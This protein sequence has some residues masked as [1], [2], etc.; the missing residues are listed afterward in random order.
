MGCGCGGTESSGPSPIESG[1]SYTFISGS[2][3][4]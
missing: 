4:Y 1:S 3:L 2:P